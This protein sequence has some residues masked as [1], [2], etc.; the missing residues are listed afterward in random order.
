M[1]PW[2]TGRLSP[3]R[4]LQA[5]RDAGELA[6]VGRW[7]AGRAVGLALSSGGSKTVAHVGVVEVLREAGVRIDAV[8]GTSGGAVVGSAVAFGA[9]AAELRRRVREL[10]DAFRYRKLGPRVPPRDGLFSGGGLRDLFERWWPRQ[11]IA[12]ASV[13][14]FIVA[15]D[16]ADGAEVVLQRGPV[17]DAVRASMGIPGVFSPVR[18]DE[19]WLTDGG[20]VTPLPAR[21]LRD[22]G[23]GVVL[24]SNV[25]GQDPKACEGD[26]P[27]G[28][29]ET[30]GRIVSTLERQVLIGQVS[31]ADVVVRPVLRAANS[32]DFGDVDGALAEGRRA[33]EAALPAIRLALAPFA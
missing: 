25:G 10:P 23:V 27:P 11:D 2:A 14:L 6:R 1:P 31:Q 18:W 20:I 12:D 13:P 4:L 26:G 7:C 33:A 22:A 21:V 29:V 3:L 5:S 15:A 32:L 19:R 9:S 17:A 8:A 28:I 16:A 30:L 24:A